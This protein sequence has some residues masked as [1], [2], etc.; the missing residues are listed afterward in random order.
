MN[1]E[2]NL[3]KKEESFFGVSTT[4][5]QMRDDAKKDKQ[6]DDDIVVETSANDTDDK[7]ETVVE[8]KADTDDEQL[9]KDIGDY[10]ENV[11]KRIDKL[12]WKFRDAERKREEAE[13]LREE[14]I[15]YAQTVNQKIQHQQQIIAN[16]EAYLVQQ[17]KAKALANVENATERYRK[18]YMEGD[19]DALIEAQRLLSI[20]QAEQLESDNYERDYYYRQQSMQQARQF[21]P[22]VQYP[23]Q[24]R[25]VQ[26]QQR[27][28]AS[29]ESQYWQSRNPWFGRDEYRDM[30]AIA[31][32][33]HQH[34]VKDLGIMP[35]TDEYFDKLDA[36][37][38][39]T[40][41]DYFRR[42]TKGANTVVA[43]GGRNNGGKPR[44]VR[45][46]E[47]QVAI[48]KQLGLT[49]EQYARQSLKES[50]NG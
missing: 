33:E 10:S 48:A 9:D 39:K 23:Q 49:P 11:Q 45:L 19:P 29:A 34:L 1:T 20:A 26:N 6:P 32:A 46:T 15:R 2:A 13:A 25:P 24:Q 50:G 5:D 28:V 41:P 31:L 43:P 8:K 17:V 40:F 16:G 47:S 35:D 4:I 21:Q 18:A 30:T 42:S 14:A 3:S 12:T 22:Q 7:Q 36:K 44:T 27:I 37:L 38:H